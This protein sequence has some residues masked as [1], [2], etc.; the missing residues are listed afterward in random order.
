MKLETEQQW[1]RTESCNGWESEHKY[2][3]LAKNFPDFITS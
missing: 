3:I 1:L 2:R